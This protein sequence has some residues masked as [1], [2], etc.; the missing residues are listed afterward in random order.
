M[1][2]LGVTS[3]V[4][5]FFVLLGYGTLASRVSRLARQPRFA[6]ITDRVAGALLIGAGVGLASARR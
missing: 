3:I 5:E 4:V 6:T 2:I 1:A